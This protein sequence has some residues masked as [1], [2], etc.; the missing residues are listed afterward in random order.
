MLILHGIFEL[1]RSGETESDDRE[2][3]LMCNLHTFVRALLQ[4]DSPNLA[5]ERSRQSIDAGLTALSLD[6]SRTSIFFK[7]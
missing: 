4:C 5:Q 3:K 2:G 1:W 7:A 6:I